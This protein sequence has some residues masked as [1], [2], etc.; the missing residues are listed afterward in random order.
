MKGLLPILFLLSIPLCGQIGITGT[1][2]FNDGGLTDPQIISGQEISFPVE[3][4][5]EVQLHYWFRLKNKR[6][7]FQPTLF[8]AQG[9]PTPK[10]TDSDYYNLGFQ[11]EVNI[12][13]F[14]FGGDCDCPTFG[15]QGP[16]LEKGFFI[17]LSPGYSMHNYQIAS[18]DG[19]NP[20]GFTYGGGVGLDFG[21][22]NFLTLTPLATVRSNVSPYKDRPRTDINGV[23]LGGRDRLINYQLGLQA[24]FRFDHKRY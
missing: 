23:D 13:P 7:E 22:S 11:F 21:I 8:Y 9:A 16:Q 20:H 1:Y 18:P 2:N 15:K 19:K 3:N 14:D 24:T 17:Q 5:P 10:S 12:Y 4:G 6:I